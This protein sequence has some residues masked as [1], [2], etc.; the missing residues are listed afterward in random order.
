MYNKNINENMKTEVIKAIF[1]NLLFVIGV[2]LMV[3]GF[4]RGVATTVNSIVFE[5]YPLD[6]Y[7]ETR[8]SVEIIPP[9]VD[10]KYEIA[11]PEHSEQDLK[12]RQQKCE[13]AI[14]K[15]RRTTQVNDITYSFGFFTSGLFICLAFKKFI[16]NIP[17]QL[18]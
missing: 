11:S 1:T 16:F 6:E 18:S 7:Q 15:A 13:Q 2:I 14:T 17:A 12:T 4:I 5:E 8:C 9:V 10:A 3:I